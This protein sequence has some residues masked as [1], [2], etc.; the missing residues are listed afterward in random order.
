[1]KAAQWR[2][3]GG[4]FVSNSDFGQ[5]NERELTDRAFGNGFDFRLLTGRCNTMHASFICSC[6]VL[7]QSSLCP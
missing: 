6:I 2:R 4:S 3:A 1:M 5:W 7:R